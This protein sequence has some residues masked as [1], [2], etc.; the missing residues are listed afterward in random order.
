M[1]GSG[2]QL[3]QQH[4]ALRAHIRKDRRET[5]VALVRA[6]HSLLVTSGVVQAGHIYIQGNTFAGC[7]TDRPE[8][9]AGQE[10]SIGS[11]QCIVEC[12]VGIT[13]TLLRS[14]DTGTQTGEKAIRQ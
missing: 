11:A 5:I 12:T 6:P 7:C 1:L 9:T 8:L 2:T 13:Q 14:R 10:P 3:I 4:V